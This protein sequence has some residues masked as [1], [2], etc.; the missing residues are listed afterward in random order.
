MSFNINGRIMQMFEFLDHLN[1]T[2]DIIKVGDLGYINKDVQKDNEFSIVYEI[3][4]KPDSYTSC[5]YIAPVGDFGNRIM[6]I[7]FV[8]TDIYQKLE[9]NEISIKFTK[10]GNIGIETGTFGIVNKQNSIDKNFIISIDFPYS[11][12][13]GIYV[14][15]G[16]GEGTYPL[17]IAKQNGKNIGLFVDFYSDKLKKEFGMVSP[18][19]GTLNTARMKTTRTKSKRKKSRKITRRSSRKKSRKVSKRRRRH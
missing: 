2:G 6:S 13:D 10:Y 19:T 17:Y 16:F 7:M 9:D 8:R 5:V 14:G 3:K 4:M 11:D 1:V 12:I 18:F 15:S